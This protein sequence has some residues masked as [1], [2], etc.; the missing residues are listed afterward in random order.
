MFATRG[1]IRKHGGSVAAGAAFL[2]AAALLAGCE[3]NEDVVENAPPVFRIV[4]EEAGYNLWEHAEH[5]PVVFE[6][7][8]GEAPFA[9]SLSDPGLGTLSGTNEPFARSAIYTP[10]T[11]EEGLNIIAVRDNN[12]WLAHASV[13]QDTFSVTISGAATATPNTKTVTGTNAIV[14][15]SVG[16]GLLPMHWEVT[17]PSLGDVQPT[18]GRSTFYQRNGNAVGVNTVR[19]TDGREWTV[20]ATIIQH[21]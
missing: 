6:V 1:H 10:E 21:N 16:G 14:D 19:V 7:E 17:D 3:T 8:G 9:W 11:G 4:P 18:E 2:I 12:G 13:L 20:E 5:Q 15:I